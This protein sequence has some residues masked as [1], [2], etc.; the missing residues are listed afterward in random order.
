MSI[1]IYHFNVRLVSKIDRRK[2]RQDI[3][4]VDHSRLEGAWDKA[5]VMCQQKY[6]DEEAF[7]SLG[8]K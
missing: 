5:E 4:T 8:R 1:N 2:T 6:P 3:V 7:L